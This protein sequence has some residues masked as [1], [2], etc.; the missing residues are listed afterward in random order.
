MAYN[1]ADLFEHTVD[2]VPDRTALICGDTRLSFAELDEQ[3]E[4]ARGKIVVFASP[5]VSYGE[6]VKYRGVGASMAAKLGDGLVIQRS[7]AT[8]ASISERVNGISGEQGRTLG[9]PTGTHQEQLQIAGE[10][11]DASA[12]TTA[13]A[14]RR[15]ATR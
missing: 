2:A 12:E 7:E 5:Y 9:R 6:T 14:V 4:R 3:P 13:E 8:P 10:L 15:R 11:A 1:I